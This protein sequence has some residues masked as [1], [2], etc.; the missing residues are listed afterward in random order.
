MARLVLIELGLFLLPFL[1]WWGIGIA[2]RGGTM[3]VVG[4]VPVWP[5]VRLATIGAVLVGLSLIGLSLF[6]QGSAEGTY[7]PDRF[8]NGHLVPGY[9]K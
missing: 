8:E 6:H 4:A 7:V 2:R 3:E 1:V 9:I 5:V